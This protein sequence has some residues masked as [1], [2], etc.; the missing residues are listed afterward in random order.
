MRKKKTEQKI[1][2]LKQLEVSEF[3][4]FNVIIYKAGHQW[5]LKKI[6]SDV[7]KSISHGMCTCTD[8]QT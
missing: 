6:E 4:R 3:V 5:N 2:T 1:V 7:F 8:T